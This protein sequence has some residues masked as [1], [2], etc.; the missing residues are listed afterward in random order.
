ME[1]GLV[2]V[3]VVSDF[4]YSHLISQVTVHETAK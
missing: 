1:I 2:V 3:K 4:V